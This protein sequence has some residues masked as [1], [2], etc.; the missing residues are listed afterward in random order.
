[1]TFL[2]VGGPPP[3][4]ECEEHLVVT[5]GQAIDGWWCILSVGMASDMVL[6]RARDMAAAVAVEKAARYC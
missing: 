1:M 2:R 4:G 3:R 5:S 6:P